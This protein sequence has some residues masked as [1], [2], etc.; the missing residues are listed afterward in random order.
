MLH[1]IG[2]SAAMLTEKTDTYPA[3]KDKHIIPI[4]RMQNKIRE[5]E[6]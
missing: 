4:R 1:T 5:L 6:K 3:K 2:T